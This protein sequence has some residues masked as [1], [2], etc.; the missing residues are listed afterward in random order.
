[1]RSRPAPWR[2]WKGRAGRERTE[3]SSS[4]LLLHVV[5]SRR[6]GGNPM[7]TDHMKRPVSAMLTK[8]CGGR[9]NGKGRNGANVGAF[10]GRPKRLESKGWASIAGKDFP[11]LAASARPAVHDCGDR[12]ATLRR[13]GESRPQ[14]KSR[15]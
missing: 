8:I 5:E 9:L 10:L 3:R 2:R 12:S 14:G 6:Q 7:P 11:F 4:W 1:N 13:N 15:G